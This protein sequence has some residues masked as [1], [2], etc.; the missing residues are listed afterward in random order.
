[1]KNIVKLP[2]YIWGAI[3]IG[4][5]GIVSYFTAPLTLGRIIG[6]TVFTLFGFGFTIGYLWKKLKS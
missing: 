1:M 4:V 6:S 5:L 2:F 3:L